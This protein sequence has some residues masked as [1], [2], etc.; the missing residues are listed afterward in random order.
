[1][2]DR[3]KTVSACALIVAALA[4]GGCS[5]GSS[6]SGTGGTDGHNGT[7]PGDTSG[8][9]S[10]GFQP[11]TGTSKTGLLFEQYSNGQFGY[12]F[13]Y[14]GG[15]RVKEDGDVTRIA[16]LGNAIVVVVRPATTQPKP[17]GVLESLDKQVA[18]GTIAEIVERPA[19][20]KVGR[21]PAM[22]MIFTQVR[23][24]TD[25]AP[26]TTMVVLRYLLF[27]DGKLAVLSLQSPEGVDNIDAYEFIV[28]R[29]SWT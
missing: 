4:F 15:W 26:E 29:F 22:R 3:K 24:A 6:S 8:G 21:A 17:K 10:T 27:H 25:T 5:T 18:S 14:P 13:P 12:T 23:P 28:R 1:M 20:T 16:K 7:A 11:P 19:I 9:S 2:A